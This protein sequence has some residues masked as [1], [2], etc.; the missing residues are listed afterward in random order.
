MGEWPDQEYLPD[1]VDGLLP[2][3]DDPGSDIWL[4]YDEFR[5]EN[6]ISVVA[7]QHLDFSD[8]RDGSE[9][10]ECVVKTNTAS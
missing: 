1:N 3:Q 5:V 7:H 2:D 9:T 8:I 6:R 4:R 10:V